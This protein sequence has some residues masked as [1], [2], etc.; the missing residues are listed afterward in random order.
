MKSKIGFLAV[1]IVLL[2]LAACGMASQPSEAPA[3]RSATAGAPAAR[4]EAST[5]S[6]AAVGNRAGQPSLTER[7]VVKTASLNLTVNDPAATMDEITG[8]ANGSG[9]YVVS[10]HS[11]H[12]GDFLLRTIT[13][14]VP[15][16]RFDEVMKSLRGLAVRIDSDDVQADDVT[17]EYTDV[18][19]QLRNL[20]ATEQQYLT[21]LHKAEKIE[22]ILQ[23]QDKLS[24]V[25]GEIER[26][27]GR[28]QFLERSAAMS[29][30]TVRL[31]PLALERQILEPGW[32]ISQTARE[33][34]RGAVVFFQALVTIVIWLAVL[35][36]PLAIA[37]SPFWLL[38]RW[39][40][41]RRRPRMAA[42]S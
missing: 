36:I 18:D 20:E 17:E 23:V 42:G 33:A 27:K 41:R 32:S 19:A 9:G 39:V 22:D 38:W 30:I 15:A 31:M 14:R 21:L 25:R 26:L 3:N 24:Q 4:R 16:E 10:S 40:R 37:L 29:A 13:I 11:E 2:A 35:A 5:E 34:L 8:L 28:K 1:A 6:Q 7:M 12:Q